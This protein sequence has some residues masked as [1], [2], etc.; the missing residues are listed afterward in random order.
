MYVFKIAEEE[1]ENYQR[2]TR[3]GNCKI[4]GDVNIK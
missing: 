1:G 4:R 3:T 2:K